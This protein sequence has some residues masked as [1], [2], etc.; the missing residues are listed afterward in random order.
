MNGGKTKPY[1]GDI[2]KYESSGKYSTVSMI[3]VLNE[4]LW[5]V[6][7]IKNK[8]KKKKNTLA[9]PCFQ[10]KHSSLLSN[11]LHLDLKIE[12]NDV[13]S[14]IYYPVFINFIK[15]GESNNCEHIKTSNFIA[16]RF[17]WTILIYSIYFYNLSTIQKHLKIASYFLNLLNII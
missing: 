17:L 9:M 10:R 14:I 3:V 7:K 8:K 5:I 11:L 15:N 13:I 4:S 1:M 6:N 16:L 12:K 2:G